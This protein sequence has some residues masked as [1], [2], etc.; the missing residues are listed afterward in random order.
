MPSRS[1]SPKQRRPSIFPKLS[2]FRRGSVDS[3]EHIKGQGYSH[4][5]SQSSSGV[6]CS[7][8][9]VES[10]KE[11]YD[12]QESSCTSGYHTSYA[13]ECLCS[14]NLAVYL[15]ESLKLSPR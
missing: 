4:Q 13:S 10:S 2:S 3:S 1:K 8:A 11:G 12:D 9:E 5:A 6:A 15:V 14:K 7:R